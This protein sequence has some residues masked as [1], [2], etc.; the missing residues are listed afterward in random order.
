MEE[1]LAET[2]SSGALD[3]GR[4]GIVRAELGWGNTENGSR[5]VAKDGGSSADATDEGEAVGGVDVEAGE[6]LLGQLQE[7]CTDWESEAHSIAL[8]V[9]HKVGRGPL[10]GPSHLRPS[11]L[12]ILRHPPCEYSTIST[13]VDRIL[14]FTF[15]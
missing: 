15:C 8:H 2:S 1:E 5:G 14:L 12:I 10:F 9:V 11:P 13:D 3:S 7:V 6:V 4:I